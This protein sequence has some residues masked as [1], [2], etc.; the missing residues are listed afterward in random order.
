MAQ[1]SVSKLR[2][3]FGPIRAVD[4]IDFE[5]PDGELISFL[6]PSGCGKTTTLRMVAGLETPTAGEIRIGDTA[7]FSER[8]IVPPERRNIGMVFQSYAIWPH[9]TVFENVAYPL[10]LRRMSRGD[11]EEK[12]EH[13]LAT[14]RMGEFSG[15]YPAQL[16]GGQ[17]QRVAL[18]RAIVFE[19]KI[20]LLDEPLSNLDAK[21]RED[22]RAEIRDL[23]QR[24]QV[25]TLYVTH[26]QQEALAISDQ[27][28]VMNHGRFMQFGRPME[29]FERPANRFVAN[30]V[31]WT[32]FLVATVLD[33]EHVRVAHGVVRCKVPPSL[34]DRAEAYLAVR[35]DDVKIGPQAQVGNDGIEGQVTSVMY[36]GRYMT[37]EIMVGDQTMRAHCPP[38]RAPETGDVVQIQMAPESLRVLEE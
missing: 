3:E 36:L 5:I 23:Q 21:L 6:G 20:L 33:R 26:D 10:R 13:A 19:P 34:P 35:P 38:S 11:I 18:A 27:V 14:V 29:I 31:G 32:N 15:R 4:D 2:K 25:T 16:S 1:L 22:M 8:P 30:F 17:Q 28:A 24:L 12:T 37:C 9:M 7:V